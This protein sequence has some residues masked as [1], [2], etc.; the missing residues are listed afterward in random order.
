MRLWDH[1]L[2]LDLALLVR[3]AAAVAAQP[4]FAICCHKECLFDPGIGKQVCGGG[5]RHASL[6]V[7]SGG[8]VGVACQRP[9]RIPKCLWLDSA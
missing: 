7:F 3:L 9:P 4:E 1:Q 6:R 2:L 8:P 5:G